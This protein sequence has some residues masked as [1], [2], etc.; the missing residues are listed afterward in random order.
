MTKLPV[1]LSLVIFLTMLSIFD[2]SGVSF[3]LWRDKLENNVLNVHAATIYFALQVHDV[4]RSAIDDSDLLSVN[5]GYRQAVELIAKDSALAFPFS[6]EM[7]T[8][9]NLGIDYQFVFP[10]PESASI[11]GSSAYSLYRVDN[12]ADCNVSLKGD[13]VAIQ[14][15]ESILGISTEYAPKKYNWDIWCLIIEGGK[16]DFGE[17]KSTAAAIGVSSDGIPVRSE[18]FWDATLYPDPRRE[19]FDIYIKHTISRPSA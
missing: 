6:I 9:G 2:A 16:V 12:E 18:A 10:Q 15:R 14:E 11:L 17:Y 4:V 3:A 1:R 5:L 8:G 7:S 19:Q 13:S